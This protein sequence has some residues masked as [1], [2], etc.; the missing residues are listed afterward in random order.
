MVPRGKT[1]LERILR[2][3]E[4]RRIDR[5]A[6]EHREQV[7]TWNERMRAKTRYVTDSDGDPLRGR[8]LWYGQ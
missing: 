4:E 3:R 2:K 1:A 7:D 6:A 8:G 5:E